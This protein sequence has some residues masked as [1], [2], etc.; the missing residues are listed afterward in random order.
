MRLLSVVFV[1]LL[2]AFTAI[3]QTASL[4]PAKV[5]DFGQLYS[6]FDW[7]EAPVAELKAALGD[8][9]ATKVINGSVESAW[10]SGIASLEGRTDN[11]PKMADYKVYY[12]TT[13]DEKAVLFIPSAEN[14]QMPA[15]MQ[16]VGDIYFL[17]SRSAVEVNGAST[18]APV[19]LTTPVPTTKPTAA[20]AAGF[21]AQMNNIVQDYANDFIHLTGAQIDEDEDGLVIQ[22]SSEAPLEGAAS[23]FFIED[24]MSATTSFHAEFPGSPDPAVAVKAYRALVKKVE[25]LKLTACK[26]S[27]QE[28]QVEG[29][30][31]K[32]VFQ[33]YDPAGKLDLAYQGML[34]EVRII[35]GEVFD[36]NGQTVSNWYVMLEVYEQ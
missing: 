26:L 18:P 31:H 34:L 4:T 13:V 23:L 36:K 12:L 25:A 17:L 10:P 27:K 35:Q 29:N 30:V 22:Y 6:T 2:S 8:A 32:Q 19:T 11:Q 33:A 14:K 9:L 15:D 20:P 16:P 3:A 7:G 24:L 5:L 28:E 21:A 1:L